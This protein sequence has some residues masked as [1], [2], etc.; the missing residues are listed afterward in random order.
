[1]NVTHEDQLNRI[2]LQ[3]KK[4]LVRDLLYHRVQYFPNAIS[5]N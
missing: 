2:R 1:M 3:E 5:I 4:G